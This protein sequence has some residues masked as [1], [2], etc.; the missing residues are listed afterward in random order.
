MDNK[1]STKF[2]N[3]KDCSVK[4]QVPR[5]I[6]NPKLTKPEDERKSYEE[7]MGEVFNVQIYTQFGQCIL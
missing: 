4:M 3:K 2:K 7:K 6:P 1:D 5:K